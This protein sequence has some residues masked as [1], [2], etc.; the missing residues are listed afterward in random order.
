MLDRKEWIPSLV[1]MFEEVRA[2]LLGSGRTVRGGVGTNPKGQETLAFDAGAEDAVIQF[3]QERIPR[4]LRLLSEERGEIPIR[5]DLGA[6]EFTLIVDPVDGSENFKRG[7]EL[8]CFSVA[9]LLFEAPLLP[10]SVIAGL[11]G[12]VFTGS[13]QTAT[14]GGGAF[15]GGSR[16][17]PS[18]VMRLADA[19]VAV[20]GEFHRQ[21][22]PRRVDGLMRVAAH[23]RFL[24]S[25]VAIQMGGQQEALTPMWTFGAV[26]RRRTSWPGP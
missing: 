18:G 6:P 8:T 9:V 3:C 19:M 1:G 7:I 16:L 2:F 17:C 22:F 10:A 15:S 21:E 26:S 20:E 5:S 24:G 12:N 13:Y 14:R 11:I 23:T 4:S 25:A